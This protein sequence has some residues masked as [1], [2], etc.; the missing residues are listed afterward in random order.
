MTGMHLYCS[1]CVCVRT[2]VCVIKYKYTN[3][4]FIVVIIVSGMF[5]ACNML[6]LIVGVIDVLYKHHLRSVCESYGF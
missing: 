3:D 2:C 1:V 6:A 4:V 5:S